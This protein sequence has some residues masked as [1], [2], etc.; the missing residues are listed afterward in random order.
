MRSPIVA[1]ALIAASSLSAQEP[2]PGGIAVGHAAPGAA[3]QTLDGKPANVKTYLGQQPVVMEFWAK[4]CGNCRELAPTLKAAETQ[5][6]GKVTFLTI[7][8][9]V[10]QTPADV[11]AFAK[12]NGLPSPILYDATGAAVDAYDVPGTSFVVV[13]DRHGKVVYTGAGGAQDIDSAVRK[14][15]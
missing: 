2:L 14:A 10:D 13:V 8:V 7:A 15:L 9:S 4:W 3:V 5:Y 1:L 11:A 6:S 12:S